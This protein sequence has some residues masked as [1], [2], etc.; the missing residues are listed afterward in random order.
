MNRT[1][2]RV[3]VGIV[4]VAIVAVYVGSQPKPPLEIKKPSGAKSTSTPDPLR[5]TMEKQGY[6]AVPMIQ[7]EK[8]GAFFVECKSGS[9]SWLM[10]LDTTTKQSCLDV[11]LTKKL[12]LS[13]GQEFPTINNSS[14]KKAHLVSLNRFSIGDFDS[15]KLSLAYDFYA[16]DFSPFLAA[17]GPEQ[18]ILQQVYGLLGQNTLQQ[19]S[20]VVDYSTLTLYLQRV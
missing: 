15:R 1:W 14:V 9:E 6:I 13:L 8:L 3:A 16:F 11:R 7:S 12:G 17:V 5:A 2:T 4:V 18:E 10:E 20:A 19:L